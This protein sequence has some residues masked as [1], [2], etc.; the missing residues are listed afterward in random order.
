[1]ILDPC[2]VSTLYCDKSQKCTS[3]P[4][5]EVWCYPIDMD[6]TMGIIG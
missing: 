5:V 2:K 1:M 3:I 6:I 4:I